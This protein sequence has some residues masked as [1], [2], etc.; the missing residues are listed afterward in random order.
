MSIQAAD[1]HPAYH[2]RR[3]ITAADLPRLD[4]PC[5][6]FEHQWLDSDGVRCWAYTV[7]G[8]IDGQPVGDHQ[9][10]ATVGGEVIVVHAD[11]RA[12]A[13]AIAVMGLQDSIEAA[14]GEAAAYIEAEAAKARLASVGP[15]RRMELAAAAP[16]DRSDEFAKDAQAVERLRGD[17]IVLTVGGVQ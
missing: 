11:S 7:G 12:E 16:A 2:L 17:D 13:D 10:G 6:V 9:G 5:V 4:S 15:V 14:A 8:L 3:R 1:C